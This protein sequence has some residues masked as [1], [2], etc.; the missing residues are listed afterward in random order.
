MDS[1]SYQNT[2]SGLVLKTESEDNAPCH[3]H[4]YTFSAWTNAGCQ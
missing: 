2:L 3:A 1:L 4:D